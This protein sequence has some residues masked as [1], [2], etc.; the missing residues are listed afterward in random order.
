M[1]SSVNWLAVFFIPYSKG[2]QEAPHNQPAML[3]VS[4]ARKR[5]VFQTGVIFGSSYC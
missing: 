4:A 2:L 5:Q 1:Y 3:R